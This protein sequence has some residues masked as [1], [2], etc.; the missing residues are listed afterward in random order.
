MPIFFG[1]AFLAGAVFLYVRTKENATVVTSEEIPQQ[2][3]VIDSIPVTVE[4]NSVSVFGQGVGLL[5]SIGDTVKNLFT[6]PG[7]AEPYREVIGDAERHNGLPDGLLGRLLYQESRYRSDIITGKTRSPVGALGVAQFM[8][9]T[10]QEMGIDPLDP[11]QAIPAAG[12]YLKRL[13]DATGS[14]EKAVASYNWGIGNV[15]RKGLE[16]APKETRDYISQI[17]SDIGLA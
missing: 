7:S 16:K 6:L 14:W 4:R 11:F 17:L 1:V 2:E 12:A 8:P 9:A 3:T 13:Y 15:K 10:A 5:N